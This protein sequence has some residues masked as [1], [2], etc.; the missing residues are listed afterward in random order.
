MITMQGT[1][2]IAAFI[3]AGMHGSANKLSH[4][5]D[6]A[7]TGNLEFI[8]AGISYAPYMHELAEAGYGVT[9]GFPGVLEYEVCERFGAMYVDETIT[10][11]SDPEAPS[12]PVHAAMCR[13]ARSMVFVFFRPV[14]D[15]C[16]SWAKLRAAL[17]AVPLPP[18]PDV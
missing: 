5:V 18:A 4:A 6:H 16:F 12:I 11:G 2:S 1:L 13:A 15:E 8:N 17:D 9:G 3:S 7:G 10:N 14:G